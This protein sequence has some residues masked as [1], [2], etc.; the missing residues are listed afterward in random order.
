M[1]FTGYFESPELI[2][3]PPV[4]RA[5]YSDRTAWIL[6][7]L[8]RL[9]YE[10][11]PKEK[12]IDEFV[13]EIIKA[14]SSSKGPELVREL[15][16]RSQQRGNQVS[17]EFEKILNNVGI[18]LID[19]FSISDPLADSQAIMVRLGTNE[20]PISQQ[21]LI[22]AFRG[23]EVKKISDIASDLRVSLV[24]APGNSGGRV[25]KGFLHAFKLLEEP[26]KQTLTRYQ[27]MPLY[28]TGHSL[29]AAIALLATR[30]LGNDSTG[31]CYTFGGPRAAD[32]E[33]YKKVKTPIY[34][35]VNTSDGVARIPL[36][37]SLN[38]IL[39]LI[40][41]IPFNG[42]LWVAK[43]LRRKV[44]GYCHPGNLIYLSNAENILDNNR[45]PYADLQVVPS[46]D[47]AWQF[48]DVIQRF[49]STAGKSVVLDHDIAI[50]ANK[51][52][53]NALRNNQ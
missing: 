4:L 42:T 19:S 5:A 2:H 27:N 32:D 13:K 49:I 15:V 51:L 39:S 12:Q 3:Q 23:T 37:Y 7:E 33:F 6:A 17:D 48:K 35:V 31:A 9:V 47:P 18:E 28:I 43:W 11:L 38:I 20:T 40:Q 36:G 24:D 46:P 30:Y 52:L 41:L 50:Y 1:D 21:M 34:R 14:A 26:L 44:L 45:I 53:A 29:G 10:K 8:S 25:H 22:L 16:T